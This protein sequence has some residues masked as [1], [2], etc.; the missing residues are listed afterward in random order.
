MLYQGDVGGF[1]ELERG[2]PQGAT[3]PWGAIQMIQ[4]GGAVLEKGV[5]ILC[6][7]RLVLNRLASSESVHITLKEY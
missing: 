4:Y 3:R 7:Q 2:W 5:T 6:G 1:S